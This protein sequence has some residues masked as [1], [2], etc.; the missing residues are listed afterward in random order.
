MVSVDMSDLSACVSFS[1]CFAAG[2]PVL[3]GPRDGTCTHLQLRQGRNERVRYWIFVDR[4]RDRDLVDGSQNCCF[5]FPSLPGRSRV[6]QD[7]PPLV[8][9][10][11]V[12]FVDVDEIGVAVS[13]RLSQNEALPDT[14]TSNSSYEFTYKH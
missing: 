12:G 13:L 7:S 14:P 4:L 5:D 11:R 2:V 6:D 9:L 1:K 10:V 8:A 3:V